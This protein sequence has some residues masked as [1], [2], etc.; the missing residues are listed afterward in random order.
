M[1]VL[2]CQDFYLNCS[3]ISEKL[4]IKIL[5]VAYKLRKCFMFKFNINTLQKIVL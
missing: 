4:R 2:L 5:S 1:T 3:L